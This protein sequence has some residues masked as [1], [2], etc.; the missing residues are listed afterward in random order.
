M[1]CKYSTSSEAQCPCDLRSHQLAK[2]LFPLGRIVATRAVLSHLEHHGI[3]A[4]LYL[5]R[6][7]IGDWG[8]V[9]AEDAQANCLAVERHARILSSYPTVGGLTI[10]VITEA[11]RSAT[12]P[13]FPDEY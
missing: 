7:V 6:H 11:D 2:P 9:P 1:S 13:L 4:D 12:T 10:W 5:K 8:T 3:A